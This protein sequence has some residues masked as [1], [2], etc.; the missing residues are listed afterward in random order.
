MQKVYGLF[1]ASLSQVKRE[2]LQ[3]FIYPPNKLSIW[4][5]VYDSDYSS[6]VFGVL[7]GTT[8]YGV[9]CTVYGGWRLTWLW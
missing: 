8:V 2:N 3:E 4:R 1:F 9:R 7:Y 6:V 5:M